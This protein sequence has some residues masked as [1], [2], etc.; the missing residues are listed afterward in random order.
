MD[1]ARFFGAV[2]SL[3]C[4][5]AEMTWKAGVDV[6][7][8]SG[9]KNGFVFGEAVI[10]FNRELAKDFKFRRKQAM[11]LPSKTRFI[12]AQFDR[13]LAGGLYL[14]IAKEQNR[15]AQILSENLASFPEVEVSR[16]T[17]SNAVFAKVPRSW[18]KP[19]KKS[20]FFYVWDESTFE[21]RLMV[22]HDHTEASFE[23]FYKTLREL[24]ATAESS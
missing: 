16:P 3:N 14:E 20:R 23:E 11:Q 17:Q 13:Y 10:F 5:P 8:L 21:C 22:T 4:A 18:I 9:T 19:L 7:S 12:A 24:Q 2:A 15:L 6:L 1:G